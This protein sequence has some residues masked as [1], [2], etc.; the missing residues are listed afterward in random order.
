MQT[1]TVSTFYST[2][3]HNDFSSIST[4]EIEDKPF[5]SGGFGDV[6][7]CS[8]INGKALKIPQVVKVF[9]NVTSGNAE[10]SYKT[11]KR[12]QERLKVRNQD[13]VNQNKPPI[14]S[15]P[16]FKAIP[17]FSYEGT[18]NGK[19]VFG[20]SASRL[21]TMGF[22]PFE[23]VLEDKAIARQFRDLNL[24]TK[25]L[26]CYHLAYGFEILK[27]INYIHADIN[28]QNFFINLSD[29][30]LA[31]I[32][33]D[34]GAVM[35]DPNH[36][37]DTFGKVAE[38]DWLAP[39]ISEQLANQTKT[40]PTIK[41][42]LHTDTWSVAVGIHYL[43]F[44]QH[45]YFFLKDLGKDTIKKYLKSNKWCEIKKGDAN[46]NANLN[47]SNYQ[48]YVDLL[49]NKVP[50]EITRAFKSTFN[51]GCFKPQD[52]VSY[53]Q[54]TIALKQS[55]TPP[56]IDSFN[57]NKRVLVEGQE[58]TLSW[59]VRNVNRILI[60][61]SIDVTGKSEYTIRP[62]KT[63]SYFI[64]ASNRFGHSKSNNEEVKVLPMPKIVSFK[65]NKKILAEGQEVILS[66]TVRNV[67]R[68]L[69]NGSIDVTGQNEHKIYPT[70]TVSYFIQVFNNAGNRS[71]NREE[72][73]VFP[74]P[75]IDNFKASRNVLIEGQDFVLSWSVNHVDRILL[76]GEIDIT[77]KNEYTI[78][79]TK[80]DFYFIQVFNRVGDSISEKIEIEVIPMPQV[81]IAFPAPNFTISFNRQ[82]VGTQLPDLN[83]MFPLEVSKLSRVDE[84]LFRPMPD[85]SFM[86]PLE[87]SKLSKV[88][89]RLLEPI[90]G[91]EVERTLKK[92]ILKIL[93]NIFFFVS[94]IAISVVLG[95]YF[96][97]TSNH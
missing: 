20:Y 24:E 67:D 76:N 58:V 38:A 8:S 2:G 60:N 56:I 62:T 35:D 14:S 23:K 90:N 94:I 4:V 22:I 26:F 5:A 85:L 1:I 9:K 55:Q 64:Q 50:K 59:S 87:V 70:N 93:K 36:K 42:N 29:G 30:E 61:G 48:K 17:Q 79:P 97:L 10:K 74:M 18:L 88:D 66:W 63:T 52:R 89:K 47:F 3:L 39:E 34:S 96:A 73:K 80:T 27:S 25:L 41:V 15:M 68:I 84:S 45:P 83:F 49:E 91:F 69:L 46:F 16:A 72:V 43:I 53:D 19:A 12:L 13:L 7:F 78:Q 75:K 6:Y 57:A 33:F 71:S 37:P 28:P 32:D 54:W 95:Y 44:L 86:F 81:V 40:V 65:A 11:I 82:A 92:R 51:D 31:I 77:G 21:D